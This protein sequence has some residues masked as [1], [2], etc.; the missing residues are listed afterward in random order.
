MTET[1]QD[2]IPHH[3]PVPQPAGAVP[4]AGQLPDGS[5][6]LVELLTRFVVEWRRG[7][8]VA[9]LCTLAGTFMVYRIKPLYEASATILPQNGGAGLSS[10]SSAFFSVSSPGDVFIGLMKSRSVLD[11]VI[12]SAGLIKYYG[13]A[14]YEQARGILLGR[15]QF[16]EGRDSLISISVRDPDREAAKRIANAFLDALEME[17]SRMNGHEA[18]V[19]SR[20]FQQQLAREAEALA[21]AD[22]ELKQVQQST[23]LV[24]PGTQTSL[25]LNAIAEARNQI[26]AL[27][28]QLSSLLLSET[29][30]NPQVKALRAQIGQLSAQEHALESASGT[31]GVGAA[32]P[33]G[34]M[35]ELNLDYTRKQREVTN[36]EARFNAISTQYESARLT[37]SF[38]GVPFSVVDR[39]VAPE[40]KA[41]PNRRLLMDLVFAASALVGLIFIALTIFWRSLMRDPANRQHLRTIGRSFYL[42]R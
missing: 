8:A 28:V 12:D 15:S 34:R 24:Q 7:L 11:A 10:A 39:A 37:E 13:V 25:G 17:Q 35:P 19:R 1:P 40:G 2:P 9:V 29:E 5:I 14:T 22:Q 30:D 4:A 32:A 41:Y 21:K 33:T 27:Q 31:S 36:H 16:V 26:T 3:P 18:E 23:G 6:D 20:F 38:S 42:V